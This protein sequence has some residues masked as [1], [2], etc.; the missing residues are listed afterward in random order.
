[1]K[2][3]G[4][5]ILTFSL[6]VWLLFSCSGPSEEEVY[7]QAKDLYATQNFEDAIEQFKQLDQ[8]Y[9]D[10]QYHAQS[11]FMIGFI[12]ANDLQDTTQAREYYNR[13]IQSYPE[14]ELADDAGYELQNLGK[15]INELPIF[16]QIT[17]DSAAAVE[18]Q[19]N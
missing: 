7:N 9:P 17:A 14:H 6:S 2:R 3:F 1:M 12:S 5:A 10:G 4:F 19:T 8:K 15:D 13:F 11:L 16:D 18:P